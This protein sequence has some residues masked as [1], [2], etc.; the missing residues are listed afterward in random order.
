MPNDVYV[1]ESFDEYLAHHG[2]LGMH[3]GIRRTPEQLGHRVS[4]ARERFEKYSEKAKAAGEKGDVKKL[5]KYTKKAERTEKQT[6]KLHKSLEKALKK[7]AEDDEKIVRKGSIDDIIKISDRLSEDQMK[8]ATNRIRNINTLN[9][10]RPDETKKIDKLVNIGGKVAEGAKHAYNIADN[11]NKFKGV[12]KDIQMSEIEEAERLEEKERA[13]KVA[14]ATRTGNLAKMKKVW[15]DATVDELDQMKKTLNNRDDIDSIAKKRVETAR[16]DKVSKAT[17][18]G[19]IEQM[20]R[21]W[22]SATVDEL[23]DMKKTLVF[24]KEIEDFS[25]G[26]T[27]KDKK[28]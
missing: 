19:D 6:V 1:A 10:L 13:Q 11:I 22:A 15:N 18:S 17:R 12:M 2:I 4:K 14:K 20:K 21:V 9:D 27:D 24:R 8:R 5:T 7:Q 3:W 28:K 23:S 16:A 26:I 25:K